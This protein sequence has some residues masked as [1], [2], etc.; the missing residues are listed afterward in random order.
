M[1]T[2]TEHASAS[3]RDRLAG[4]TTLPRRS[5]RLQRLFQWYA[6][7]FIRKHFHSV[8]LSRSGSPFPPASN[9]PLLVVLNHPS[10]WDP[11]LCAMLSRQMGNRAHYAA[12]DAAAVKQY[13]FFGRIGFVGVESGTLRGAAGF[14]RAGTA[15]LAEPGRVFWVTAQGRF[16]DTRVRPLTLQSGVGH[17]AA[18]SPR[19]V[20]LPVALEYAFWTERT[21]EALVRIGEPVR[22]ADHPGLS[23]KE[24]TAVIE[25]ALTQS[26]DVLG[27]E[28]ATRDPLRFTTIL[29]GRT[30]IGGPYDVWRRFKALLTGQTFEPA[31]AAASQE[32]DQ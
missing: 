11:L 16:T 3:R 10:W 23:G 31:H 5:A 2:T 24:W 12:I 28:A 9:E 20:I 17:L 21:P 4:G 27:A 7:R 30:G 8:R 6:P 14:V 19:A 26:L 22:V 25:E 15:I 18:R 32:K 29:T 13:A 1:S